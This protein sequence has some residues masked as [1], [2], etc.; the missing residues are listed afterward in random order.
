MDEHPALSL[1]LESMTMVEKYYTPEQLAQL[2]TLPFSEQ[3]LR[4]CAG[5]HLLRRLAPR[6]VNRVPGRH[7]C[8]S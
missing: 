4:A 5:T 2:A 6:A 3:T 7:E 8:S 1:A